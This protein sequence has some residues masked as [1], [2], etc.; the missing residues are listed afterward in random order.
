MSSGSAQR[1]TARGGDLGEFS[2]AV[3]DAYFPHRLDVRGRPEVGA[4]LRAVDLGPVRLARIGW[5]SEVSVTSDHP[6]AWAVNVPRSGVLE[7][8]VSGA[9]VLS[10]DGQATVC[11]PDEP[12]RMIRWSADCAIVGMRIDRSYLADDVTA[13]VGLA[14]D[15]MPRQLDLRSAEGQAWWGLLATLGSEALRNPDLVANPTVAR[16]MAAT[17]TAALVTACFPDEPGCGEARPRIVSRVYDAMEAD[18]SRDWTAAEMAREAGVG[19]RRL[20]QGFRR[21]AGTTPTHALQEIRL[22]R[23]HDD[24]LAGATDTV[25]D[26]AY[27][28]GFTHLGRFAAAYRAAYGVPPSATLRGA[29]RS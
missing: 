19:I 25:A 12:T 17:L 11:P 24:L 5:G 1:V 27:R 23:V 14:A 29:G 15:S 8:Q 18:P 3:G 22:A 4:D 2:T 7:A 13:L 21:Y 26:A 16:R 28:W 10:L 9:H 6:G 20:Q